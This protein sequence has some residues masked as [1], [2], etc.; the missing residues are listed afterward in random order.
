M[1]NASGIIGSDLNAV[2]LP[3]DAL[4]NLLGG[5]L[6]IGGLN[7][8]VIG[9]LTMAEWLTALIENDLDHWPDILEERGPPPG[10][11]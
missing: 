10:S 3:P 9:D 11:D 7:S 4:A 8:T 2:E 6:T 1:A 5:G